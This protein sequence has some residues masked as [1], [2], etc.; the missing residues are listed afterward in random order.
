MSTGTTLV[1]GAIALLVLLAIIIRLAE[2]VH[3]RR[4]RRAAIAAAKHR[5]PSGRHRAPLQM[6]AEQ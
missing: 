2:D 4:A 6:L 3:V 1:V 5:H